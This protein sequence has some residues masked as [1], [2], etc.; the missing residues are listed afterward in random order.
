MYANVNREFEFV[1]LPLGRYYL[2]AFGNGPDGVVMTSYFP[3]P[4]DLSTR[5]PETAI[6]LR[7]Y[8]GGTISGTVRD[9]MGSPVKGAVVFLNIGREFTLEGKVAQAAAPQVLT[10][11]NGDYVLRGV[12]SLA[13]ILTDL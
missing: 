11:N 8:S 5:D 6:Y 7:L 4:T 12:F 10:D 13:E 3:S 1:G 2:H 9:A